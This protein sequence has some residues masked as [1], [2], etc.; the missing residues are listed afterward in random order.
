[1]SGALDIEGLRPVADLVGGVLARARPLEGW[2]CTG[3]SAG[4]ALRGA[5]ALHEADA[6]R[7]EELASCAHR[8]DPRSARAQ[9]TIAR[10]LAAVPRAPAVVTC[11]VAT[12]RSGS[13]R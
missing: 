5:Q 6:R 12:A 3:P 10:V 13:G 11:A 2:T 8:A 7:R 1:M 9:A 4:E